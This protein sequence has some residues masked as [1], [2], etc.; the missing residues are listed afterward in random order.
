MNKLRA[1]VFELLTGAAAAGPPPPDA[2]E[3]WRSLMAHNK[4]K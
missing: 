3:A 4:I 1:R 2:D